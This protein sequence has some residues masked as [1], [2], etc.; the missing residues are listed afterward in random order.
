VGEVGE[1]AG[2]GADVAAEDTAD[3]AA[4]VARDRAGAGRGMV[5]V[6]AAGWPADRVAVTGAVTRPGP[7]AAPLPR[8][9]QPAVKVTAASAA[10][11]AKARARQGR[12]PP[13]PRLH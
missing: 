4:V 9:A 6:V 10:A 1:L 5:A 8:P 7:P 3:G 2:P 12:P 13:L 11:K